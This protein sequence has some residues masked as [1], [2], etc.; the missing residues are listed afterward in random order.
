MTDVDKI[1]W[2]AAA[3]IVG[4]L[5]VF[6]LG[7]L[8]SRFF[9]DPWY[10]QRR[11][12]GAI[13]QT[14]LYHLHFVADSSDSP[15]PDIQVAKQQMRFLSSELVART[16]AIPGYPLL[17][18]LRLAP[19]SARIKTASAGLVGL[20]NTLHR[21]DW[22]RKSKLAG[23]VAVSLRIDGLDHMFSQEFV[24]SLRTEK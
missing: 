18:T 21:S 3:T 7:Q 6:V 13:A 22:V 20:S 15:A 9:L 2:T 24:A 5:V 23:Q 10:E 17:A 1:V 19:S 16:W 8:G 14:L 11:V 12:V 4:G